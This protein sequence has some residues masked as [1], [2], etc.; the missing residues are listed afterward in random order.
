MWCN[1]FYDKCAGSSGYDNP[2]TK[3]VTIEDLNDGSYILHS[4]KQALEKYNKKFKEMTQLPELY[5]HPNLYRL[6]LYTKVVKGIETIYTIVSV[7]AKI[8]KGLLLKKKLIPYKEF[9]KKVFT[10]HMKYINSSV[11]AASIFFDHESNKKKID[12]NVE[13]IVKKANT[14]KEYALDLTMKAESDIKLELYKYQTC[15]IYWMKRKE[16]EHRTIWYNTNSEVVVGEIYYDMHRHVFNNI[17]DRKSLVFKGG[18]LIDEVGLGKTAQMI[19]LSVINQPESISYVKEGDVTHMYSRAT[20]IVCP[21]YLCGHWKREIMKT[22]TEE[23]APVIISI[24]TKVHYNK[25]TY[26]DIL[27]ADYVIV[28]FTFFN[29]RVST[30]PWTSKLSKS[31]SYH[32]QKWTPTMNMQ[33]KKIFEQKG[34]EIVKKSIEIL[35]ERQVWIQL[36]HWHRFII[37]EFHEVGS[38]EYRYVKNIIKHISA[39]HKWCVTA[40]P[41]NE[42]IE[43]VSNIIDYLTDYKNAD[44]TQVLKV[45]EIVDYLST[46]CFRRNTKESVAKEYTLPKIKEEIRWLNFSATERLIYN[47]YIA[48]GNNDRY[49][50]YLRQLCCHPQLADETKHS[51]SNCKSLKEIEVMMVAHYKKE[52]NKEEAKVRKINERIAKINKKIKKMEKRQKKK[53]LKRLKRNKKELIESDSES[54]SLESE[55]DSDELDMLLALYDDGNEEED[56]PLVTIENLKETL[57]KVTRTLIAAKKVLEG[58]ETTYNFFNNVINKLRKTM[59]KETDKSE[60]L[61]YNMKLDGDTNIMNLL[62]SQLDA[63]EES[64]EED[65][66]GI[67]MDEIAEDDVGVTSCGHIF[68][69]EC[70]KIAT[71]QYHRCPMCQKALKDNEIYMLSYEKQKKE[72]DEEKP[73]IVLS[74]A[75]LVNKVGTKLANLILYIKEHDV[76]TIIF[77]QWD[78]LLRRV[79]VILKEHNVNNIFCK[80]NCYQQDKAIREF[81]SDDKIKVIMLSSKKNASGTN[82]T[83][84]KMIIFLDPIYGSYKFRKDQ[85]RQAIG[86]A[87]R[88]GQKNDITI[89]RFV[90]KNS[91]EEDIYWMNIEEDKKHV[92][93]DEIE[94]VEEIEIY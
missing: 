4:G 25:Y 19:A 28:S 23:Y 62:S 92:N 36:I 63:E 45:E 64:E 37:D 57:K 44:G 27:D 55:S 66:C 56:K 88:L 90:I 61:K 77:S 93:G 94:K 49:S 68:C 87:H 86:R 75:E 30:L 80:G 43:S 38:N 3:D 5:K 46:E 58:K 20:L 73:S 21:N 42:G 32:K 54:E 18:C 89:V 72:A 48:N 85:E 69:Y 2:L 14:P 24:M 65:L 1:L 82:L 71:S 26:Q 81:E 22:L 78:D 83:K 51:L 11:M 53:K 6:E 8:L 76:H 59:D 15:S 67:C 9:L 70:L 34:T 10:Y 47:A 29:N 50:V 84:A 79:G 91:I 16:E 40:T 31:K 74:K 39:T 60:R 7:N 41:F 33:V 17:S 12:G 52:V 13:F 35:D